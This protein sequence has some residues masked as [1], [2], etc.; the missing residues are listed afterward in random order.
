M[1]LSE[2][3][4]VPWL[5]S[6]MGKHC[7]VITK[8]CAVW[9]VLLQP[10]VSQPNED[11]CGFRGVGEENFY[12]SYLL[13][14]SCFSHTIMW[15]LE[16]PCRVS[17]VS[18]VQGC[19]S[20]YIEFQLPAQAVKSAY[21]SLWL[22]TQALAIPNSKL[23]SDLDRR[24]TTHQGALQESPTSDH[25]AGDKGNPRPKGKESSRGP[26]PRTQ[27][28]CWKEEC[29]GW[30]ILNPKWRQGWPL[31]LGKPSAFWASV[32]SALKRRS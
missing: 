4:C 19:V 29:T 32:S 25:K 1:R 3:F 26:V 10:P 17:F 15:M 13:W 12:T 7:M 2:G 22:K 8:I 21:R 28:G 5:E 31:L 14:L 20:G 11:M 16:T 9:H 24:T 18:V 30:W 23:S 27:G 6:L